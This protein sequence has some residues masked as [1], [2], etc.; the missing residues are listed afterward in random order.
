MTT[1]GTPQGLVRGLFEEVFN[2]LRLD[3]CDEIIAED[4]VE[5]AVAPFSRES[6]G[7]VHGP[8][9]QRGVVEW[10]RAQYPDLEMTILA[11]VADDA[12]V[13]VHVRSTGTNLGPING[14]I[15][16][17]GKT[18][19]ADQMHRYRVV[20]GRLAEHWAVRDDLGMLAQL[21]LVPGGPPA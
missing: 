6:P 20:D 17:T 9:H 1:Y 16:P 2:D 15:P 18:A 3:V 10:L 13:I 8:T 21:G 4:Y 12:Q 7:R 19:T 11:I 5:H 14:V